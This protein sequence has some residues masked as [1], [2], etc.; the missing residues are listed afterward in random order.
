MKKGIKI[1]IGAAAGLAFIVLVAGRVLR[2]APELPTTEL[3]TVTLGK[4]A[5]GNMESTI[6]LMGTIQPSDTYYLMPKTAGEL[7]AVYV[8]NGQRVKQGDP[9]AKLDNQKQIDAAKYT[10]EQANASAATAGNALNRMTPLY[11]A[12][13]ISAQEYESTKAQATAA[14]AQ[15]KSAQLN[16]DTQ[17]EFATLTAPADGTI[18]NLS[19]TLNAMLTQSSQLG[20]LVG[21]GA[22]TVD[23]NVTEDVM[24]NLTLGEK[25][26]VEK[27][28]VTI[29]GTISEI[30]QV[31]NAQ[32]GLFPVKAVLEGGGE[33]SDGVSAKLT[34]V[35]ARAENTGII[36]LDDIYYSDSKPYVYLYQDG[37][38][39]ERAITLGIR[40]NTEAQVL[41]GLTAEDQIVSSW[42]KELYDG[43]SVKIQE[44]N[45]E[46][47]SAAGENGTAPAEMTKVN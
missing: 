18:Q 13:D 41:E 33:L 37:V 38:V 6:S 10:L 16:Y 27:S 26:R 40:N 43:A 44:A 15:A 35:S 19:Y 32:N 25:V 45:A 12:G 31:V 2:P 23:F 4:L 22:K 1:G 7:L 39:R 14:S 20:I 34:L 3:P 36:P 5:T 28:G 29:D 24:R 8:E 9:I 42:S 17:M 30:G 47:E 46:G 11:Q 21:S